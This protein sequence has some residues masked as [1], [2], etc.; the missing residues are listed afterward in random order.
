[1]LNRHF[2]LI[3]KKPMTAFIK[4]VLLAGVEPLINQALRLDPTARGLLQPL[5]G[6]TLAISLTDIN[7]DFSVLFSDESITLISHFEP[8]ADT[9]LTAPLMSLIRFARDPEQSLKPLNIRISGDIQTLQPLLK[10][11]QEVEPDWEEALAGRIGD[12]AASQIGYWSR[13]IVQWSSQSR[14][15]MAAQT[16]AFLD[17]GDHRYVT[18]SELT[19][20]FD[21]IDD[22]NIDSE[23]LE[24]K[25]ARLER[26]RA[27]AQQAS[28]AAT[29]E[30]D[31]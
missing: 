15:R 16:K 17:Q 29:Q 11:L 30:I 13:Q 4:S 24:L 26:K 28:G 18:H 5:T 10:L 2:H 7:L 25:V 9:T 1:M 21:A 31:P 22:F 6:K 12:S 8:A 14:Q 20:F 27:R 23:R 3:G 19:E